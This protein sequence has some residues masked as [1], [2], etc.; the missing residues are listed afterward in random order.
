[1]EIVYFIEA[2]LLSV[3]RWMSQAHSLIRGRLAFSTISPIFCGSG[4]S[5]LVCYLEYDTEA[6]G[7]FG[8]ENA[9]HQWRFLNFE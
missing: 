5:L 1:M 4:R 3:T 6:I 2:Q 9:R 7:G 8:I